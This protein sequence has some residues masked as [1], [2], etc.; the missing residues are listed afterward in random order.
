MVYS[1]WQVSDRQSNENIY[2]EVIANCDKNIVS[3]AQ[4]L[5]LQNKVQQ[6]RNFLL[7]FFFF[8]NCFR[9]LLF[10]DCLTIHTGNSMICSDI[11]HKYHE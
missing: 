3:Y 8:I 10:Q 6:T 9:V 11:W 4:K 2:F 1:T 7:F 5:V